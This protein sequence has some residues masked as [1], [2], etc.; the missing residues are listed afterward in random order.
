MLGIAK[1]K[2]RDVTGV[3][4]FEESDCHLPLT[5]TEY[6]NMI[7]RRF[8]SVR[9]ALGGNPTLVTLNGSVA[10]NWRH[11]TPKFLIINFYGDNKVLM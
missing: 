3:F 6:I 11:P 4:R 10:F 2:N 8:L 7:L 9:N 1:S 5:K